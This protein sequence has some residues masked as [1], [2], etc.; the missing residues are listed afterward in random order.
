MMLD[1]CGPERAAR[2]I[3][4]FPLGPPASLGDNEKAALYPDAVQAGMAQMGEKFCQMGSEVY[5]EA[6]K[7]KVSNRAS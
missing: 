4:D 1:G 3:L 2:M 6:D 7:V 5:V